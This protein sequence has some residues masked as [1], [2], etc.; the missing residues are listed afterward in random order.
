[1]FR[2]GAED[3]SQ[4]F[5]LKP[6][7]QAMQWLSQMGADLI[8]AGPNTTLAFHDPEEGRFALDFD[9]AAGTVTVVW[10]V[11]GETPLQL[12]DERQCFTNT[13]GTL[14]TSNG[15]LMVSSSPVF[16]IP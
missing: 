5:A 12:E 1:L 11:E 7:G 16:L 15:S 4:D 6:S 10:Q 9:S 3:V 14:A 13:G 8:P 2:Y